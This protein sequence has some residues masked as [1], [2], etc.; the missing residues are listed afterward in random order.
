MKLR[1]Y[2]ANLINKVRKAY[3]EGYKSPCI[4]SP[5]GSGKSVM[6]AE[7]SKKTTAKKNRVL[8]LVH[9][10]EL[11]DQI[12]E[13]FEWWG[14]DLDY[15]EI[16]MVQTIVRRLDKTE[17]P[18]LIITDENHH[19]LANSYKK[20]Y[21][22]FPN[23]RLVGFT[24]TPIRLNGGG[25]GEIN[26]KLIIGP[27]VTELIEWGNLAP[28]KYYA[29]EVIDTSKLKV[30]RGEYVSKDIED[31]F[32]NKAIWGDVVK[33]YKKLS[34]EKQAICY[35]SSIK[36]SKKMEQEFNENEIVAKHIDGKTPKAERDA[37]I[38]YFRQGKIMVL[39]N[40]DLISEGFDV[41]DCN[42]AILLRPTQSLALYIQ[43]SMRAMR[44]KE[45]K[46]AIIIDHVGNVGR[47]GTP[48]L[49]REWSLKPK[50]GS[51]STIKEENPVKQCQECFY[52]VERKVKI[53]PECGFE[54]GQEEK[55]IE[56]VESELVEIDSI[57]GF[58]TDYRKPEDCKNM[59][60]LYKLAK[61]KGYKPGWAWYQGKL[62][63]FVK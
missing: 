57:A 53:C 9:R 55:E 43:Q 8:F 35:C 26:D 51:N 63:G 6:I 58:T 37:A 17:Q 33:H 10:K 11:K 59:A 24:A 16:G 32:E 46:T 40:V 20:I 4:V 44:Y 30:R 41:P 1:E 54:F 39:C 15:V 5:C 38:E 29:P 27:T 7:I 31:L 3:I 21:K 19:S 22:Y 45:G 36:Q 50:K 14:V 25:L 60:E 13:T 52:T 18:S 28:F 61:H 56:Q 47:F 62:L 23:A 12:R 49:D 34:D 48:D 2:Q 42:T